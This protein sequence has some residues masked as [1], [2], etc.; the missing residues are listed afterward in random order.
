MPFLALVNH[1]TTSTFNVFRYICERIFQV[2]LVKLW[3]VSSNLRC[4][5]LHFKPAILAFNAKLISGELSI[6][7]AGSH[8]VNTDV[9]SLQMTAHIGKP[10]A[11][12]TRGFMLPVSA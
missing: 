5:D 6:D 2:S 12:C 8:S 1:Y 9:L 10:A 4:S 3:L 11:A 7:E